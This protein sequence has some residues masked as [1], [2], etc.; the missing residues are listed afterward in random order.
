M[1]IDKN[2][3]T[4]GEVWLNYCEPLWIVTIYDPEVTWSIQTPHEDE[5]RLHF[6]EQSEEYRGVV[7]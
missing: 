3:Y 5:A 4:S 7:A 6:G 2:I 1:V